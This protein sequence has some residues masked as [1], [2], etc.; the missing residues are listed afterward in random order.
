MLG[1]LYAVPRHQA[2]SGGIVR[3]QAAKNRVQGA[4]QCGE[5]M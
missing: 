4:V 5:D 2:A 3:H 1:L